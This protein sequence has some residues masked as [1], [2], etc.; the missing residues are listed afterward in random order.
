MFTDVSADRSASIFTITHSKPWTV[1]SRRWRN[2]LEVL[3]H[4]WHRC[5]T[6]KFYISLIFVSCRY[7]H[8][9]VCNTHVTDVRPHL[10]SLT[11]RTATPL[12]FDIS[13]GH[14][15]TLWHIVEANVTQVKYREGYLWLVK[16]SEMRWSSVKWSEGPVKSGVLYLWINNSRN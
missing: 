2:V 4:D 3:S 9:A 14:T 13:Y 15:F 8:N 7:R 1:L 10:Y 12:L 11:Y 16:W 6:P 5:E